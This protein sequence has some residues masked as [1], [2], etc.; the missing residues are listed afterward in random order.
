MR[1][2]AVDFGTKRI[3]LAV[4]DTNE[5][6]ATGMPTIKRKNNTADLS[7]I[8]SIV[9]DLEIGK[10][11]MGITYNYDGSLS[12]TGLGAQTFSRLLRKETGI[13][14]EFFDETY[15]SVN[16]ENLL[17][18]ADM[19]RKKR[20]RVIDKLSAVIILQEYLNNR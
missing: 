6:I 10:I 13:P 8:K 18:E 9:N 14:V 4:S 19:S 3:G 17:I 11:I 7:R 1:I 2:L 15:T 5:K 16:A 20:K 12:K